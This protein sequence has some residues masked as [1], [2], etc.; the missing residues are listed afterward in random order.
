M[1]TFC[2]LVSNWNV[3]FLPS[4]HLSVTSTFSIALF[5]VVFF[6]SMHTC[7]AGL[8]KHFLLPR[9]PRLVLIS[10]QWTLHTTCFYFLAFWGA[11]STHFHANFLEFWI[12]TGAGGE[13]R[14]SYLTALSDDALGH[15]M[16]T[17]CL[18]RL[19]LCWTLGLYEWIWVIF[20]E[21]KQGCY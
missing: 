7:P 11:V 14:L 3:F 21:T 6:I 17:R 20:K 5:F 13:G 15:L 9:L 10:R 12:P 19:F 2:V 16:C 18:T 1:N 8:I 4:F